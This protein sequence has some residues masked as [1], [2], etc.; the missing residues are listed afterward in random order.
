M[1]LGFLAVCLTAIWW[2]YK[3]GKKLKS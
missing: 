2:I 1:T 3:T